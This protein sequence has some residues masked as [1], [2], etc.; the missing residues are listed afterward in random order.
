MGPSKVPIFKSMQDSGLRAD[1]AASIELNRSYFRDF[2]TRFDTLLVEIEGW[3]QMHFE[4]NF[5]LFPMVPAASLY[6][7]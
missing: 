6:D 1:E 4:A 7:Y 2:N 5:S 3:N